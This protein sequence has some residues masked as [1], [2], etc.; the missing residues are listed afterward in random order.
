MGIEVGMSMSLMELFKVEAK[1]SLNTGYKWQ[2]I[3]T[4]EID[5]VHEE[6]IHILVKPCKFKT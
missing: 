5:T 1:A 4:T 2:S 6:T 3:T